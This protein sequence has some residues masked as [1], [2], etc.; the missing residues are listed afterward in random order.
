M[1][2]QDGSRDLNPPGEVSALIGR[3]AEFEGRIVF[4]GVVRIDG[5]FKG[6]VFTR[7]TLVIGPD[8]VVE[9]QIDADTVLVAGSVSGEIRAMSRVE[10]FATGV[11]RGAVHTPVLKI[12][13]GGVFDGT[14]Q[15]EPLQKS[16]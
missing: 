12:E 15:M 2:V 1:S 6:D 10:I 11:V 8:A 9:A 16:L 4:E 14:T 13:E 7:D 5:S 3:G